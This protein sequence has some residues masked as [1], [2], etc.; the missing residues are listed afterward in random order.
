MLRQRTLKNSVQA[1]GIGAH[2]GKKV[3]LTLH[4]APENTGIVFIRTD[5]HPR[6][7]IKAHPD[8]VGD[9][10]MST[11]LL[12]GSTRISTV[13][14]LLSAFAGLKID[15]AYV[16]VSSSELPIMDGSAGTYV[17]L[18]QSAGIQEQQGLKKFIRIREEIKVEDQDKYAILRPYNGFKMKFTIQFD[19]PVLAK[20]NQSLELD[21]SKIS[22][23]K[24]LSRARTFG[25][26]ADYEKF[27]RLGLALGSGL[28]NTIVVDD[29]R[30]INEHG[31]RYE[32]EFVRHKV[33]DALG[34]LYLLGHNIIGEFEGYKSGH[35]LNN[36]LLKILMKRSEAWEWISFDESKNLPDA[37]HELEE[38]LA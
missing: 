34:D 2:S 33:L 6:V 16:E 26:L 36:M 38:V 20:T 5:L 28:D 25:F 17:F 14:H 27:K 35:F 7:R 1:T 4:P 10:Q 3:Y 23:V 22:Y 13:E 37:Y 30:I 18:I 31:L 24:E 32:D 12:E 11:T 8:K 21:F 15:N 29:Y 19:H 9:T